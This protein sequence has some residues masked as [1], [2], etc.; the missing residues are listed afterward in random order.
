M[1]YCSKCGKPIEDGANFCANCGSPVAGFSGTPVA[2]VPAR[3]D[4]LEPYW[5][6]II[7][8]SLLVPFFGGLIIVVLSSVMYYV[9]RKEFP[10]KAKIINKQGFLAFFAG[11]ALGLILQWILHP[12]IN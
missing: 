10:N 6:V 1:A 9:W 7:W 11:I 5:Y 2:E 8:C 12:F 4:K 3:S